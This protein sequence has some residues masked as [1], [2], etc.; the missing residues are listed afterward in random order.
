ML[1]LWEGEREQGRI[2]EAL[3]HLKP[4]AQVSLSDA[5]QW[6]GE[7]KKE[8]CAF[9]QFMQIISRVLLVT[10]KPTADEVA[11]LSRQREEKWKRA[12]SLTL[13]QTNESASLSCGFVCLKIIAD[14]FWNANMCCM[15]ED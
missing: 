15:I 13:K 1:D 10:L 4:G 6:K 9:C 7:K 3:D 11:P 12:V 14:C 5:E 2:E 8:G